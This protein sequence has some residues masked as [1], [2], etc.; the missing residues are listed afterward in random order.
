S[1]A[2]SPQT[3]M[4]VAIRTRLELDQA[5]P[6]IRQTLA[7]LDPNAAMT[8]VATMESIIS[9]SPSVFMR[10]FP[11]FLV[12]AFALTALLLAVVGIYGVVSYSV[13][14]R[15]REMG[16]RLALGAQPGSL[17]ALV[18]RH[19]GWMA[20]AGIVVGV[21]SARLLGRF[22]ESMLFGVTPGDPLTYA[23]VAAVLAL[24][25]MAATLLPARRATR[26]DP[27]LALRADN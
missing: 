11:L 13:A 23:G 15:Q 4:A 26:V 6:A 14:Q 16:I 17:I 25:A 20:L 2:K 7:S 5:A 3:S 19:G 8:P 18:V 9:Q 10:R 1:F 24:V 27:A 22:A 21:I 12:G